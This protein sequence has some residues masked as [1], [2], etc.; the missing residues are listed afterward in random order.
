[1]IN[2]TCG[3]ICL[4][5]FVFIVH[6]TQRWLDRGSEDATPKKKT[7][8]NGRLLQTLNPKTLMHRSPQEMVALG[9]KSSCIGAHKRWW[10]QG[11]CDWSSSHNAPIVLHKAKA[12]E[13]L[14]I[15]PTSVLVVAHC[16]FKRCV[17]RTQH[18]AIV[19]FAYADTYYMYNSITITYYKH[20]SFFGRKKSLNKI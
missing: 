3:L 4:L 15:L 19:T 17:S 16:F 11:Q 2:I 1:M 14:R 9:S 6:R 8:S 13:I 12:K 10:R 18:F 20:E 5:M 7:G